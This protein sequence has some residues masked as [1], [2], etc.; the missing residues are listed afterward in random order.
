[1]DMDRMVCGKCRGKFELLVNHKSSTTSQTPGRRVV[2]KTPKAPNAF[3]VFVRENYKTFRTP[4]TKH[5]D[6]MKGL[7]AKF[8]ASKI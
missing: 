1:M 7:S 4:G 8:A 6:A 3:A 2:P 5:A